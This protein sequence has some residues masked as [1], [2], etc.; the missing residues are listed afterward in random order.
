MKAMLSTV[1][2]CLFALSAHANQSTSESQPFS[3]EASTISWTIEDAVAADAVVAPACKDYGS[4]CYS[5][6]ECCSGYCGR[7]LSGLFCK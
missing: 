1:L 5:N 6:S 2:L 4:R 7:S 3:E